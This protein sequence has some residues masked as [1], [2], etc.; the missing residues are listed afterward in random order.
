MLYVRGHRWDYDHWAA[1]GNAGWSY[2]DVLPYFRK[3]EHNETYADQYHGQDGPLNVAEVM[4]PSSMN[5]RFLKSAQA[6]GLPLI[7][8]YNVPEPYGAFMYQVTQKNG[9][10]CS[11]AKA[12]LTPNLKRA[13]LTVI[14]GAV[15]QRVLFEGRKAIGVIVN[16]GGK[17]V[18]MTAR[19][20]VIL[21]AGAFGSPQILQLSGI[22]SSAMLQS[23]G[24][25]VVH[26]L[27][28][29]GENLQDHIDYVYTYR[30]GAATDTFGISVRGGMRILKGIRQWRK[31]RTGILTTP[32]AESGAFF[33]SSP[34][35]EVPDLQLV[36]VQAIVDDH[37]RKPHW[38]HGIS[39]HVTLLRPK[40]RGN[41]TLNTANAYDAPCIDTAFFTDPDDMRIL[42]TGANLQRRILDGKPFDDIRG[43]ALYELNQSDARAV[44][45][46]IRNRADTQYHPVGTCK[47]GHDALAVVDQQLRVHGIQ[48]LR[49]A[50][51]SVMPTLVSG[52]TNA[53][54]IMIGEKAAD[55]IKAAWHV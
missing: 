4:Q 30:T 3:A 15:T 27:P 24:I 54:S 49:V 10:R 28:G 53:P 19:R 50:D 21:S 13:N 8:D 42:H 31:Q 45:Q 23:K 2:D 26:E 1:L 20:E 11:S 48:N 22:G 43:K 52:N 40:S 35:V 32:Y 16:I 17:D 46:D 5:Q 39:C 6:V 51:A 12:Y 55:M 38:G 41:V 7:G 47:M 44:E 37:G 34:D 18:K 25:S 9:E 33:R 36:F 29:V 14:T